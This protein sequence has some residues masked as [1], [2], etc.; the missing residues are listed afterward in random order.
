MIT[1]SKLI[2]LPVYTKNG[3]ALGRIIDVEIDSQNQAVLR[4]YVKSK[5]GLAGLWQDRLV[6]AADQVISISD[7]EMIVEDLAITDKSPAIQPTI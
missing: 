2:N 4:Y 1:V 7:K 3:I 5:S 6:I